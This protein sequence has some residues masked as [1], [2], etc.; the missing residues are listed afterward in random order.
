MLPGKLGPRELRTRELRT[1]ELRTCEL[2]ALEL[3]ACE[4]RARA[5]CP[6]VR[7][8]RER[9]A[10]RTSL[11]GLRG[12]GLAVLPAAVRSPGVGRSG[13]RPIGL[14]AAPPQVAELP[15]GIL[16]IGLR[17]AAR[18]PTAGKL[19]RVLCPRWLSRV[20]PGARCRLRAVRAWARHPAAARRRTGSARSVTAG[21]AVSRP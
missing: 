12:A 19:A 18:R 6:G 11:A 7:L 3:G 9:T 17:R 21:A 1:R 13:M 20:R 5:E 16:P 15:A 8:L 4:L 14:R 2:G 10:G